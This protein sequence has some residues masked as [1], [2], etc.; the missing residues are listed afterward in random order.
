[1]LKRYRISN[2]SIRIAFLLFVFIGIF[3]KFLQA[4]VL[5][6]FYDGER[7]LNDI[8]YD[9]KFTDRSYN[10]TEAFF[11]IFVKT[12]KIADIKIWAWLIGIIGGVAVL[13]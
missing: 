7:I 12:F 6:Q 10:V 2:Q 1:M 3:S 11:G 4:N 5:G 9:I 13:R 8:I